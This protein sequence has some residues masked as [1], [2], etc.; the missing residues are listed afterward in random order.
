MNL[1]IEFYH[2]TKWF[3]F[4]HGSFNDFSNFIFFFHM[5]P[6]IVYESF[7]RQVNF[8]FVEVNDLCF[9]TVTHSEYIFRVIN[10]LPYDF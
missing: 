1:V 8:G 2:E 6:W 9:H 10:T 3:Y 7:Y 4:V 5:F